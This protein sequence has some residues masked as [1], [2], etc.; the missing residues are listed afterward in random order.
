VTVSTSQTFTQVKRRDQ[1]IGCAIDAT[2]ELGFQRASVAEVARRAGVSKGVVTYHFPAKDELIRAVVADVLGAMTEYLEPR[3]RAAEPARLPECFLTA[4]ITGWVGYLRSHP[5]PVIALVRIYN[6]YR[7]ESGRPEAALRELLDARARDV[8][9]LTQVLE[10]G[11][12][13]GALAGFSAPV[14]A[15]TVKAALD[16]LM[17]QFAADPS[18]DV[19]AYGTELAALFE[20]AIGAQTRPDEE[21]R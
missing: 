9:I 2:V 19:D 7:D 11:Q 20:R 12:A 4:Y 6:S 5:R 10:L 17:L 3:L 16:D 1:L 14:M 13:R 21:E 18:L 8:A 15:A